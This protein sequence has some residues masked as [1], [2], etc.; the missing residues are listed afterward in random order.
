M[1]LRRFGSTEL[2]V[3][4]LGVGCARIGGIFQKDPAA[5]VELLQ[6][7]VAEGINFFDTADM[8][9][10]GE[11][12]ELLGRALRGQRDRV[13]IAT[14]GGYVLPAQRRLLGRIKPLV[15]PLIRWL[16]IR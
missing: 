12:E 6:R 3:S 14:K 11:S 7:A 15:R 13:V 1:E 16:K 5:F 2:R 8:Y 4:S 10:Q 9:S